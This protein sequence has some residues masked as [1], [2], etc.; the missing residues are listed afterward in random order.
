MLTIYQLSQLPELFINSLGYFE[1]DD[2]L[3]RKCWPQ[4]C[5]WREVIYEYKATCIYFDNVNV[6]MYVLLPIWRTAD[7]LYMHF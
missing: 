5:V 7:E 4:G 3:F 1:W 2:I 6:I